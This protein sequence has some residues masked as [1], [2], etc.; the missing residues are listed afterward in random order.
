MEPEYGE[1][2]VVHVLALSHTLQLAIHAVQANG[3]EVAK[4]P[5]RQ[6]SHIKPS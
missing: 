1:L 2:Q 6:L 4:Y 3:P 5:V